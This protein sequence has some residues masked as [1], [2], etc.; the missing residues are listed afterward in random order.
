MKYIGVILCLLMIAKTNGQ[1]AL[2]PAKF[3]GIEMGVGI[4]A[5]KRE[6][7]KKGMEF[8]SESEFHRFRGNFAGQNALISVSGNDKH[9]ITVLVDFTDESNWEPLKNQYI[10]FKELLN[11]KYGEPL[12]EVEEFLSPYEDGHNEMLAID[13]G[14][15]TYRT[16]F[17]QTGTNGVVALGIHRSFFR[18][19]EGHVS[20]VYANM[21]AWKE[22]VSDDYGDL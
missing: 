5:F 8:L 17:K 13:K 19:Y 2:P 20:I 7:E 15:F 3:M 10:R 18:N 4:K 12:E 21:S 11:S 22:K 14:K 16:K 9:I 1:D 6:L